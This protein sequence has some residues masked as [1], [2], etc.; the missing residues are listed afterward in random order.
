MVGVSDL[1]L[2]RSPDTP[3]KC[4]LVLQLG[5]THPFSSFAS[6]GA[7]WQDEKIRRQKNN[8]NAHSTAEKPCCYNIIYIYFYLNDAYAMCSHSCCKV[9]QGV[10]WNT[11]TAGEES[12]CSGS[13]SMPTRVAKGKG[14]PYSAPEWPASAVHPW[15]SDA[16]QEETAA[17]ENTSKTKAGSA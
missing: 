11:R 9:V 1:S 6:S 16:E 13:L 7:L 3:S 12:G 2:P 4:G 8:W 15:C 5:P 10:R 17:P 14:Q